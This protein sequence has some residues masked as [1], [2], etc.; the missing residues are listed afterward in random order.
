MIDD[1][2]SKKPDGYDDIPAHIPDPDATK[3]EDWDYEDDGEWEPPLIDNPEF[4]GEWVAPKVSNPAYKGEWNPKQ[5]KNKDF[6]EGVQLAAFDATH[7][8]F[9]L[10]I[11][12]ILVTDDLEYAKAQGEKLW[13]P[14]AD[15]EKEKKEAWDKEN[16][17]ADE[18][19]ADDDEAEEEEPEDEKDEL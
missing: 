15:G 17:P 8:G 13:R 18:P 14:T 16:K 6:E 11:D 1:P 19:P 3:P 4:K 7:V 12:N 5:I 9:E 10:W 2:E